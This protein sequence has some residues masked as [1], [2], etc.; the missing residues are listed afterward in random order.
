LRFADATDEREVLERGVKRVT[1][2]GANADAIVDEA[3]DAG[4]N[5]SD[6]SPS[7][8]RCCEPSY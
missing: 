1:E 8:S 7:T 4:L 6:R 2:Q 3:M 5:G